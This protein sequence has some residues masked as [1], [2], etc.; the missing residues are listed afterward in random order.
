M[1]TTLTTYQDEPGPILAVAHRGGAGEGSSMTAADANARWSEPD[2][3]PGPGHRVS[4]TPLADGR[5]TLTFPTGGHR[6]SQYRVVCGFYECVHGH[7]RR[8][9]SSLDSGS[10]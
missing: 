7:V 3:R 10:R 4:T 6:C 1:A 9:N 2:P 5:P 8:I